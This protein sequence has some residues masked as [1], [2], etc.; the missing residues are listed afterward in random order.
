ML[1]RELLKDKELFKNDLE[2]VELSLKILICTG[3]T[4]SS[5]VMITLVQY[6]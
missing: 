6:G 1:A 3:K 5:T 4:L 2:Y